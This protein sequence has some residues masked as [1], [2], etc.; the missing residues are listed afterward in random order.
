MAGARGVE[1]VNLSDDSDDDV[2]VI[3]PV[4]KKGEPSARGGGWEI[5][6]QVRKRQRIPGRRGAGAGSEQRTRVGTLSSATQPRAAEGGRARD[7]DDDD[8]VMEISF[9]EHASSVKS[10]SLQSGGAICNADGAGESF[11]PSPRCQGGQGRGEGTSPM[12][13]SQS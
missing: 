4:K 5:R 13:A 12:R 10:Q 9:E 11:P 3:P 7:D 8:D 6:G 1:V 2:V